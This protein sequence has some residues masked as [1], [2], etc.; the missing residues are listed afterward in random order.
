MLVGVFKLI[1]RKDEHGNL[2]FYEL[3]ELNITFPAIYV[4]INEIYGKLKQN[5]RNRL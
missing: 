3:V 2:L 1:F 5:Y 4:N